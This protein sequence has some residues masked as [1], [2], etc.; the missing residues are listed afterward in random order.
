M[1][2]E[3][4]SMSKSVKAPG[5]NFA[6]LSIASTVLVLVVLLIQCVLISLEAPH[7][8]VRLLRFLTLILAVAG[9]VTG[10][11][12]M[13]KKNLLGLVGI[14]LALLGY[15]VLPRLVLS[16]YFRIFR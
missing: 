1:S 7:L 16:V 2:C 8:L 5:G 9:I 3:N 13:T 12:A 6:L 11:I 4:C 15:F 10:V 14:V